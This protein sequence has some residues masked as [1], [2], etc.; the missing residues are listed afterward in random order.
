MTEAA[1][2][3]G[4]IARLIAPS[5]RSAACAQ[6]HRRDSRL[7]EQW[8]ADLSGRTLRRSCPGTV[9]GCDSSTVAGKGADGGKKTAMT[10]L[11]QRTNIDELID[12]KREYE[13]LRR[14]TRAGS[15]RGHG[16]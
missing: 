1:F 2:E 12:W 6:V 3:Q 9:W 7:V 13:D 10:Y 11:G 5:A 15:H 8:R 16:S 4:G 14:S